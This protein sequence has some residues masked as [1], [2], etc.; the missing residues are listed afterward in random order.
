M[1]RHMPTSHSAV[2]LICIRPYIASAAR[3]GNYG[4]EMSD[5]LGDRK[6]CASA[7]IIVTSG[8]T[9]TPLFSK[10]MDTKNTYRLEY[11][12]VGTE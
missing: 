5:Y 8:I 4:T 12:W 6:L 2:V 9:Y 3:G 11:S 1:P 10:L 7:I